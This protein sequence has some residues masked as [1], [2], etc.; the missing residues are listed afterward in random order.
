MKDRQDLGRVIV[1]DRAEYH[2][3]KKVLKRLQSFILKQIPVLKF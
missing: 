1:I 2:G 3:K